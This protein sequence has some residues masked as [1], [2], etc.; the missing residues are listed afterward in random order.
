MRAAGNKAQL[1]ILAA[2]GAAAARA[3][4]K[5][6]AV[7]G[8]AR[9]YYLGKNTC[10]IDICALGDTRPLVDFCIKNYGARAVYFNNFGT[11]RAVFDGGLKID[12]VR[13]RKEVYDKPAAL[14]H[15]AAGNLEDDLYR[16]DFTANAWALSLLPSE[17]FKSYD[18]FESRAAIDAGIVKILH[19]KSFEDDPT[20]VFRAVRF[21]ARFG[22][23]LEPATEKLLKAAVRGGFIS[24]L[25]RERVRQELLKILEE[26]NPLPALKL[27]AE[28]GALKFVYA[29][30]K[31]PPAIEKVQDLSARLTLLALAQ[32]AKGADFLKSLRL[33]RGLYNECVAVV[34]FFENKRALARP[35]NAAQ[36]KIARLYAPGLPAAAL[37]PLVIAGGDLQKLGLQGGA[38]GAALR[39]TARLQFAGEI[40][41]KKEALKIFKV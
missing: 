38:L 36:K 5:A 4:L 13:C 9:D 25:S 6:W 7:G 3:G 35:L 18:L 22:W 31:C 23:R 26:K 39:K 8:F 2:I 29:G 30:L 14:P 10:D 27:A 21:A 20:R 11:A 1:K 37:R 34:D 41:T 33:E 15:V 32:G 40:R 19:P 16:R 17:F 12:F 24:L 28:Y